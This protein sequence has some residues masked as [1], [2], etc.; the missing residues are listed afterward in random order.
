MLLSAVFSI[1]ILLGIIGLV[2]LVL[3]SVSAYGC[4]AEN[5]EEVML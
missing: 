5:R 4:F 3:V 1:I 2:L